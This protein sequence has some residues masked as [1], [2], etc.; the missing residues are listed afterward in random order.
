[1]VLKMGICLGY[2]ASLWLFSDFLRAGT[3]PRPYIC[4][5][6]LRIVSQKVP[7]IGA[8]APL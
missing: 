2:S 3:E 4:L 1:M 6:I 5:I 8:A 7:G